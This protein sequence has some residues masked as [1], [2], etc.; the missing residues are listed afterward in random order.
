MTRVERDGKMPI[1]SL[2]AEHIGFTNYT[3]VGSNIYPLRMTLPFTSPHPN[4]PQPGRE[5]LRH[6]I[7][8]PIQGGE[9]W[10]HSHPGK[11]HLEESIRSGKKAAFTLPEV[12]ITIG[13]IGIVAAM[14]I[15]T[16]LQKYTER[17]NVVKLK[18]AYSVLTEAY[19]LAQEEWGQGFRADFD[20]TNSESKRAF[21]ERL[22]PYLKIS[23]D[24][25][26]NKKACFVKQGG[27]GD[28]GA[29]YS[30]LE[31][32]S[33]YSN[34]TGNTNSSVLLMDGSMIIIQTSPNQRANWVEIGIDI[35][36]PKKPNQYGHDMFFFKI[37]NS[38]K[39]RIVP[40]NAYEYL[41]K[42]DCKL[43]SNQQAVG[44]AWWVLKNGNMDYLHCDLDW[45]TQTS[46]AKK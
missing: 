13:V 6:P 12:L 27:T 34:Q 31:P 21:L 4:P 41:T 30:K 2:L 28:L 8:T 43:N 25:K 10:A 7:P 33:G 3:T 45:K 29:Y 40:R 44:C 36:G 17:A 14:T 22:M 11:K 19:R 24:C 18:R 39:E 37:E 32:K 38:T 46:C 9:L 15:P 35:N 16:L 23:I 42:N 20:W 5:Q 1:Y 26:G